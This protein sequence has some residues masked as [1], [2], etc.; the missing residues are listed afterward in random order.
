MILFFLLL[1]YMCGP[2]WVEH[3]FFGEAEPVIPVSQRGRDGDE[4][5]DIAAQ[6]RV[7]VQDVGVIGVGWN[8]HRHFTPWDAFQ[9]GD[10]ER[11]SREELDVQG[12]NEYRS[13]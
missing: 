6:F 13:N 5:I 1:D 8:T 7:T 2:P 9:L 10:Q 3:R 4:D 11:F 12:E